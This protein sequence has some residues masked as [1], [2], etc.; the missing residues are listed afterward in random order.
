MPS[1][2][3]IANASFK[4]GLQRDDCVANDVGGRAVLVKYTELQVAQ[5]IVFLQLEPYLVVPHWRLAATINR[6]GLVG[7]A[8]NSDRAEGV[9]FGDCTVVMEVFGLH[10]NHNQCSQLRTLCSQRVLAG[11]HGT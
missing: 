10:N 7:V 2:V 1:I 9:L 4:R 3:A 8:A 11:V 5:I 6:F